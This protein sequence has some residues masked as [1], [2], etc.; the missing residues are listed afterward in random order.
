MAAPA[1][2]IHHPTRMWSYHMMQLNLS[3]GQ[4]VRISAAITNLPPIVK[5]EIRGP[6]WLWAPHLWSCDDPKAWPSDG[7]GQV[8]WRLVM[9]RCVV[10]TWHRKRPVKEGFP[11]RDSLISHNLVQ[12]TCQYKYIEGDLF[13]YY[14]FIKALPAGASTAILPVSPFRS[15]WKEALTNSPHGPLSWGVQ[16]R[17]RMSTTGISNMNG[18]QVGGWGTA[19]EKCHLLLLAEPG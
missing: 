15:D 13:M 19:F 16:C 4:N 10:S 8:W 6:L 12:V 1:F 3:V 11:P 18:G 7:G 2:C 9:G 14:F 5:L 17:L